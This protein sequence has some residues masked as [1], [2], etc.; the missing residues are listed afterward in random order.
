MRLPQ[1]VLSSLVVLL[2][3]GVPADQEQ[4]GSAS[5]Y[6]KRFE[7]G[8]TASGE[9][10]DKDKMTA[11]S[12][13]LPLGS[14]VKVTDKRTGKSVDVKVNDRGPYVKGRKVDLSEEAAERLGMKDEGTAP[15]KIERKR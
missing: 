10:F 11:A 2:P 9:R 7:G 3:S 8:K 6:G 5:Y 12:P 14:R 13:N 15:V 1:I 4:H